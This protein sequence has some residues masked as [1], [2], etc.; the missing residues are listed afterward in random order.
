[1]STC[2]F[3][4]LVN[5]RYLIIKPKTKYK[6][7]L[8]WI[9][10]DLCRM[11]VKQLCVDFLQSPNVTGE[12][13]PVLA[14]LLNHVI[15]SVSTKLSVMAEIITELREPLQ[16]DNSVYVP[17]LL[18]IEAEEKVCKTYKVLF[19]LLKKTIDNLFIFADKS[20]SKK[21]KVSS[22]FLVI[23]L[24]YVWDTVIDWVNVNK[25]GTLRVVFK[26]TIWAGIPKGK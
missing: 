11:S 3:Y 12:S 22:R 17:D 20:L 6:I 7:V 8:Y 5:K 25:L 1:M 24:S 23:S 2:W 4:L 18:L 21:P 13:I 19:L 16:A 14:G 10:L 26:L 15:P 9:V